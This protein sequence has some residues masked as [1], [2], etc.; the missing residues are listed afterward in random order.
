MVFCKPCLSL[1]L[2]LLVETLAGVRYFKIRPFCHVLDR[3]CKIV[4]SKICQPEL[5]KTYNFNFLLQN[6][7]GQVSVCLKPAPPNSMDCKFYRGFF[8]SCCKI[9]SVV[10]WLV[11]CYKGLFYKFMKSFEAFYR[12]H[13]V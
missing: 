1:K 2:L 9:L 8:F 13:K 4:R 5:N 7:S 12:H 11:Y 6:C 3:F 10:C